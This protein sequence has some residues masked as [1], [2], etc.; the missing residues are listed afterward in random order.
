MNREQ[1]RAARFKR[2]RWDRNQVDPTAA[3]RPVIHSTP[4]TTEEAARLSTEARIGWH[5]LCNGAGTEQ[6]FD[7]VAEHLNTARIVAE[8]IDVIVA[9]A[10]A[11]AQLAMLA[12]QERYRRLGRF[13][14]DAA[15]LASVPEALDIYD[16]ML[17][18]LT[19]LQMTNALATSQRMVARQIAEAAATL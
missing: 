18:N 10:I 4:F 1:R 12:M 14:P 3:L 2:Q 16:Q 11:S 9:D 17:A 8:D 5:H 19:P 7:T 6:H 13:G 15:A